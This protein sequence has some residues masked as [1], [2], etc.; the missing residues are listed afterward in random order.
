MARN[1]GVQR[2]QQV[3][4][5]IVAFVLACTGSIRSTHAEDAVSSPLAPPPL[6]KECQVPGMVE[7]SS[8]PLPNTTN[9]LKERKRIRI[10]TIGAT[11][12]GGRHSLRGSYQDLIERTLELTI[13]GLDVV[14]IKRGISGELAANAARRL[15]IEVA[16]NKPDLVLWQVGTND[17][18]AF[19]PVEDLRETITSTVHWLRNHRI[20]VVLVGL[21]Y[22]PHMLHDPSYQAIRQMMRQVTDTEKVLRIRLY[23]AMEMILQ[24]QSIEERNQANEFALTEAG[25][26]CMAEYVARAITA[27]VFAKPETSLP[28]R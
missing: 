23:E 16:V 6:S 19:V 20:D 18:M 24:A 1:F 25:Y 3:L 21:H 5:G 14:L 10:L 17:A 11:D 9:A 26:T 13:K 7:A 22:S 15:K 28:R 27:G 8:V 12:N 2:L 4:I